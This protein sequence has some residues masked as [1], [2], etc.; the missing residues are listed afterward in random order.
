MSGSSNPLTIARD[1]TV[2]VNP[3]AAMNAGI[4]GASQV[5]DLRQKQA[6]EAAGQAY[7]GAINPQTGEFDP[8][9]FRRRLAASGPAAMAAGAALL[10]TQNISSDQLKQS[11][12]KQKWI[13]STAGALLQAGDFSD[14][15]MLGALHNG[16]AGHILTLPEAQAQLATMPPD[17]EG[18]RRWLQ[19][20]Q[21]TSGSYAEQMQ[22]RFGTR[23]TITT[24]QGT[25]NIPVPSP[26]AG[27]P[28]I[29]T[30][31]GPA[32]GS[33]TTVFVPV[34]E[35]GIIPMNA[36]GVPSRTPKTWQPQTVPVT[37]VP[38]VPSGGPPHSMPAPGSPAAAA[39]P[40]SLPP[41]APPPPAGTRLVN[42]KFTTTPPA[43][44]P[45]TT[46]APPATTTTTPPAAPP[47][48]VA[49]AKS[50]AFTSPPQGQPDLLAKDNEVRTQANLAM[51]DQQKRLIAGQ[52]AL[53][54]LKLADT[55]PSTGFFARAYAFLKAQGITTV[56]RGQLSD[57][58]YRQ[59]LQKNLLR[60][61]QSSGRSSGTDLG[62]E[63][64]IHEN[65]NVDDMLAGAN[66]HVL[67]QDLGILKR[68]IAQTQEMPASGPAGSVVKHVGEFST[69]TAPEAFMWDTYT[70]PER[71]EIEAKYARDGKTKQLHDSLELAV[72]RGAIPDPRKPATPPPPAVPP[73]PAQNPL[74]PTN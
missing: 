60:F 1:P 66:R 11:L 62:L 19:V 16:V 38:G 27:A 26:S 29:E 4:E 63:T 18:R 8:N 34:D 53:E 48:P 57:T 47:A 21:D 7:Q 59:L 14:A 42:G 50:P 13:N 72:R 9:E 67:I 6:N 24:P 56:E 65:A 35:Q 51:P 25:Y 2:L 74:V 31:H 15:A 12:D 17:A 46:A 55:G 73:P 45:A 54:A 36:N 22:R 10:N 28:T 5:Y 39:S 30:P 71:A 70:P 23:E 61:A 32:P 43:A 44:T 37:A 20:H 49:A 52:S 41:S 33:T 40:G 3:L 64:K 69:K 68:D 58:D